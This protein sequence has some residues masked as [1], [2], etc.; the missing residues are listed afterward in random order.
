MR[1]SKMFFNTLREAPSD[2]SLA[3]HILMLRGGYIKQVGA[4]IYSLTPL[5]LRVM[6]K[7][8]A[9]IRKEMNLIDGQEVSLPVV[10]P[11]DIWKESGRY[12]SIKG[13]LLRFKDRSNQDMVL[14]MTHEEAVT[15]LVRSVLSS[16]KQLPF[17]LYQFQN[18]FRDEARSR[19]GLIRVREFVMKDAYSFHANEEDLDQ[20]YEKAYQAYLNI[21]RA[22]DIEPVVVQSDT[23]IMGGKIAHEFMMDVE[24]GEDYLIICDSC[25]YQAN[26]EIADFT[27]E[28]F[29][30]EE[31]KELEKVATPGK[32]SIEDVTSFLEKPENKAMKCVF[33][34]DENEKLYTIVILGNLDVSEIKLKNL[35]KIP[36]IF[37]AEEETIKAA[38]MVPGYASPIN[39]QNTTIILDKSVEKAY[40][41]IAGAN[42]EG[43]HFK[44]C[45]P[46]RD[47]KY[48]SIADLA[49]A[50]QGCKCPKCGAK[51]RAT[52]GIEL[53][54]IFKLGTKFSESM[55]CQFLDEDSKNKPAVMG[56]YGIGIGRL[57]ASVVE[58]FHDDWGIV[59]P[60]AIAPYQVLIVPIGKEGDECQLTAE[61]LYQDL[62]TAGY[63]VLIDDRKE[64]PG[65][66]FKDADLWGIPVRISVGAKALANGGVEWK[67]R[68]AKKFE[69]VAVDDVLNQLRDFYA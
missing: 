56:C 24:S 68:T 28:E 7:I 12:D 54:N 35:L 62:T 69:I 2:A 42:E 38:G 43:F 25:D 3:S 41:L 26:Q 52:R 66:K 32:T 50:D 22:I 64:R 59:W 4:G 17:M 27:R 31:L 45:N 21:F 8:E 11:A 44:N 10:Q 13:E 51:L 58:K 29:P 15:D 48:D 49:Q 9:I 46:S 5:G 30:I 55:K 14:A 57:A 6:Q 1:V 40:N 33:Y 65:V 53:G 60:K 37:V 16:H 23:G 18:K 61:K 47:F 34:Q 20:Y 39:A 63:E 36:E 19:G 67:L